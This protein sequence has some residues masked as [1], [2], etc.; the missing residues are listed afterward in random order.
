MLAKSRPRG[1]PARSKA[2]LVAFCRGRSREELASI[3][4]KALAEGARVPLRSARRFRNGCLRD[5]LQRIS[6]DGRPSDGPAS[7]IR[8]I[9]QKH[10]NI[11]V[12]DHH[13]ETA[14][15]V[16]AT[17]AALHA[18]RLGA[19]PGLLTSDAD[20]ATLRLEADLA[21][22][23]PLSTFVVTVSQSQERLA[24]VTGA[25]GAS[26]AVIAYA[27]HLPPSDPAYLHIHVVAR[28]H[29]APGLYRDL[30]ANGKICALFNAVGFLIYLASL[31][32]FHAN[33]GAIGPIQFGRPVPDA[34]RVDW[35]AL[36]LRAHLARL[37]HPDFPLLF[38]ARLVERGVS[39]GASRLA[40][41]LGVLHAVL[42]HEVGEIRKRGVVLFTST[43]SHASRNLLR[44][45]LSATLSRSDAELVR[46]FGALR[47]AALRASSSSFSSAAI[48]QLGRTP[49]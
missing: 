25:L 18:V 7:P 45:S 34:A 12:A 46:L 23:G 9:G 13:Q 11:Y 24:T 17:T 48:P 5:Y 37:D 38:A 39:P 33:N 35:A 44:C 28:A 20:A 3:S 10:Y 19:T 6:A 1:R 29:A 41:H 15:A 36:A 32:P 14:R 43:Y 42:A 8:N 40:D 31:N 27:T 21:A 22:L 49:R 26:D 16:A 47:T 30:R 4:S 2:K